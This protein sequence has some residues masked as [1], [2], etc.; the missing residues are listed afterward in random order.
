MKD[1]SEHYD[2]ARAKQEEA[3][4]AESGFW[5]RNAT[6]LNAAIATH[7]LASD[8]P[9][10]ILE[11]G[12]GSGWIPTML[13]ETSNGGQLPH[14]YLGTDTNQHFLKMAREKNPKTKFRK[15]DVRQVDPKW[16]GQKQQQFAP[17][18]VCAFAFLKHFGLHEWVDIVTGILPLAPVAVL[19]IQMSDIDVDDGEQ[20]GFHHT[21]I[22]Q[23]TLDQC[24]TA[25]G[26][27]VVSEQQTFDGHLGDG[28]TPLRVYYKTIR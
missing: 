8:H 18:L 27:A 6:Y 7:I 14:N 28:V 17:D 16:L 15:R 20:Y 26:K 10:S 2:E 11:V 25:T 24:L 19:E 5:K 3:A 22:S 1:I 12:C 21:S 9:P 13:L 23:A 4:W